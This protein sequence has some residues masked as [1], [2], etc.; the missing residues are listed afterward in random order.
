MNTREWALLVFTILGQLATGL[1]LVLLIV[2]TFAIRKAGLEQ[3]QQW[4]DVPLYLAFPIMGLGLLAAL[5]HL[6]KLAHVFG[7]TP[8]LAT[9][10]MSWEVVTAVIFLILTGIY[11]LLQ[12]RKIASEGLRTILA[13]VTAV[14]GLVLLYF[15]SVTY[16]LPSQLAWETFATPVNFYT[17]A[18]LLGV[19]GAACTLLANYARIQ[20]AGSLPQ[21]LLRNT[22]QGLAIA[23]FILMGVEF[24]VLP[25]YMAYLSTQGPTTIQT[26]HMQ[27]DTYGVVLVMRLILVFVGVG[28]L[29]GYLYRNAGMSSKEKVLA[30]VTY[31]AFVLVLASEVLGRFLFY[32]TNVRIGV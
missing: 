26:L 2:R 28:L 8:N 20:K 29:A 24:L 14:I 18:L 4:T 25:I 6:G 10:M 27:I 19:L 16:M 32:A 31:I 13:W 11:A 12:W 15:M 5:F 17:T 23:A 21:E 30:N 7:A 22:L 1:F 9:S 3:A